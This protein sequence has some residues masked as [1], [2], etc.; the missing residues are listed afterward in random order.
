MRHADAQAFAGDACRLF[1]DFPAREYG[2]VRA[3]HTLGAAGHHEGDA[4]FDF[5]RRQAEMRRQRRAQRGNGVFPGEIID[6]AIALGFAE[7]RQDRCRIDRAGVD[8]AH[9]AGH[10]AGALG[11]DPDDADRCRPHY[12]P[13]VGFRGPADKP[14][15]EW[16]RLSSHKRLFP[17]SSWRRPGPIAPGSGLAKTRPVLISTAIDGSRGMGPGLRQDDNG[18]CAPSSPHPHDCGEIASRP[19]KKPLSTVARRTLMNQPWLVHKRRPAARFR[20][21]RCVLG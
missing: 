9:E 5:V 20:F 11:G 16:G 7:D 14:A 17:T 8:H 3:E 12:S 6:A 18:E 4:L 2:D 10:V 19:Q 21:P 13:R 1:A 15:V